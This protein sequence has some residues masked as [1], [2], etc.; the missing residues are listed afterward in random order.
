MTFYAHG[1]RN[2]AY[3]YGYYVHWLSIRVVKREFD[4]RVADLHFHELQ[5]YHCT[6][7]LAFVTANVKIP[8]LVFHS[9]Y[10]RRLSWK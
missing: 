3:R 2:H 7:L 8:E 5:A 9:R 10:H 1:F 4:P 6:S